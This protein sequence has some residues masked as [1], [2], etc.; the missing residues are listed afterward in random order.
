MP[1][2]EQNYGLIRRGTGRAVLE[3]I[4]LPTLPKDYILI[5]VAAVA[6]NPTDWTSLEAT[7]NDG[8]LLGCDWAGTVLQIG[9]EVTKKLQIGDRVAGIGHGGTFRFTCE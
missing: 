8:T 7:G 6:L 5:Q 4:P 2:L 1:A 9:P 3:P